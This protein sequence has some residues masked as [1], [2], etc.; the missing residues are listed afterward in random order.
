MRICFMQLKLQGFYIES[1]L[2]SDLMFT[3]DFDFFDFIL[4][5]W[6]SR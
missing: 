4:F 5:I 6:L 1:K 3:T 2:F